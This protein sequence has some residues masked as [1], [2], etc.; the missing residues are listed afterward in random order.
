MNS[1]VIV[2]TYVWCAHLC[3][4]YVTPVSQLASSA[5]PHPEQH[6]MCQ[7]V[8]ILRFSLVFRALNSQHTLSRFGYAAC[9]FRMQRSGNPRTQQMF[10]AVDRPR[11]S[12]YVRISNS[13]VRFDVIWMHFACKSAIAEDTIRSRNDLINVFA[14]KRSHFAVGN[15][16]T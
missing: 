11:H 15:H 16:A 12:S 7:Y 6:Q 10:A 9:S 1:T 5:A 13:D 3:I 2:F 14:L 8:S 4:R